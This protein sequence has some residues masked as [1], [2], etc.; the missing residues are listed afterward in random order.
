VLG[1]SEAEA[2]R[3]IEQAIAGGKKYKDTESMI[4]A[5]YQKQSGNLPD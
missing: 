2:H 5:I 1:H 3:L 4:Q